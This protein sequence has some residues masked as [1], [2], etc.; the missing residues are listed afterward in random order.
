[1]RDRPQFAGSYSPSRF[2]QCMQ[3]NSADNFSSCV[4]PCCAVSPPSRFTAVHVNFLDQKISPWH[5]QNP[6]FAQI[7]ANINHC[8]LL[9]N[10]LQALQ[11]ATPLL[12]KSEK[13]SNCRT[14]PSSAVFSNHGLS[15]RFL[16]PYLPEAHIENSYIILLWVIYILTEFAFYKSSLE[17]IP[18][19]KAHF[20]SDLKIN[21]SWRTYQ[22]ICRK[23]SNRKR[24]TTPDTT[25]TLTSNIWS[26]MES[27]A[28]Q[29]THSYTPLPYF[30]PFTK[31]SNLGIRFENYSPE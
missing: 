20:I 18:K 16:L 29:V 14:V 5:Q 1:M 7:Q 24:T 17:D 15:K 21:A 30:D 27:L 8:S 28:S 23:S 6:L 22:S 11:P 10:K 4:A 26:A 25:T 19:Q 9:F 3:K 13:H 2:Q 12:Q 31:E